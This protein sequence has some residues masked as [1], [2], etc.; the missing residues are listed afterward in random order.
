M[1]QYTNQHRTQIHALIRTH[2]HTR[3]MQCKSSDNAESKEKLFLVIWPIFRSRCCCIANHVPPKTSI[4]FNDANTEKQYIYYIRYLSLSKVWL[5]WG[6]L[7]I[8]TNKNDSFHAFGTFNLN[9]WYKFNAT[10]WSYINRFLFSAYISVWMRMYLNASCRWM[11]ILFAG[12]QASGC[13]F[14]I[15]LSPSFCQFFLI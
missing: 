4:Y 15:F 8:V 7:Y 14:L 13:A 3:T 2:A 5:K 6:Y 1:E 11:S 9:K 10:F 12:G